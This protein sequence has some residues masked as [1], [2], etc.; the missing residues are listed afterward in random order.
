MVIFMV[1]KNKH[2]KHLDKVLENTEQKILLAARDEFIEKGLGNARMQTIADKA[3]VNKALLHYYF[4]SKDK[5]FKAALH[6]VISRLWGTI[7]QQLAQRD[8]DAD[9]RTLI[10]SI[11]RTYITMFAENPDFPRFVIRELSQNTSNTHEYIREIITSMA[12][13]PTTII[14]IYNK[15]LARGT[16][17]QIDVMHFMINVMGMCAATFIIQPMAAILSKDRGNALVFNAQF[18]EQ[19]IRAITDMTCDGIFIKK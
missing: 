13:V 12:I 1:I 7:Q 16:I 4:R 6:D 19:R 8:T 11:V 5:L 10:H 15:E 18:Y 2:S 3:G 9:L 14:T 17:K